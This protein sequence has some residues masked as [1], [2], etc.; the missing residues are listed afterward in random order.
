MMV[1]LLL[2]KRLQVLYSIFA[3]RKAVSP[4]SSSLESFLSVSIL[5][6]FKYLIK[7]LRSFNFAQVCEQDLENVLVSSFFA[8]LLVKDEKNG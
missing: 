2:G 5:N 3:I 4:A 6:S 7:L 1:H 8:I